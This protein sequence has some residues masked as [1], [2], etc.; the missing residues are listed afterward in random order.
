MTIRKLAFITTL[1]FVSG[2]AHAQAKEDPID[3]RLAACMDAY[4][5]TAGMMECERQAFARWDKE[6]NT[7]YFKLMKALPP[8]EQEALRNAQRKWLAF[9]DAEFAALAAVYAKKDGTMFRPMWAGSRTEIVKAR[10]LQLRYLRDLL[11]Y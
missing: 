9:R 5:S 3:T 4:P 10:V 1:L 6:L 8:A 7:A 11:D 2:M